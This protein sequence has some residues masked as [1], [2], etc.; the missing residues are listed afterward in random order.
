MLPLPERETAT[1]PAG[2]GPG[3]LKDSLKFVRRVRA[4]AA[5]ATP[6][7]GWTD[8]IH[9]ESHVSH[10]NPS[11]TTIGRASSRASG[12]AFWTVAI[13][14]ITVTVTVTVTVTSTVTGRSRTESCKSQLETPYSESQA[15]ALKWIQIRS[16][17]GAM[18][19]ESVR[20]P[21]SI[22]LAAVAASHGGVTRIQSSSMA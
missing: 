6:K 9:A 5:R 7:L 19:S 21:P 1:R 14:N 15:L 4:S 3:N 22:G 20:V 12:S 10:L 2:S 16:P 11:S 17:A 8:Q 13:L 18:A